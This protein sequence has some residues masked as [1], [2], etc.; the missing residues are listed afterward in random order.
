MPGI[1]TAETR[2]MLQNAEIMPEK[3]SC[4]ALDQ[5]KQKKT[6][7]YNV[8]SCSGN[9]NCNKYNKKKDI[10]CAAERFRNIKYKRRTF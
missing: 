4:P 6:S 2:E 1:R 10:W 5:Q 7:A 9:E 8:P 3:R